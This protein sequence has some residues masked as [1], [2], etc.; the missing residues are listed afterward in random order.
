MIHSD[1]PAVSPVANIIFAWICFVLLDFEKYVRTDGRTDNMCENN[2]HYWPWL[3]AGQ[4]DQKSVLFAIVVE[5]GITLISFFFHSID[6][7]FFQM[8]WPVFQMA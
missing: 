3:W 1:R 4:V 2:D 7:Q 5:V 8:L 6:F